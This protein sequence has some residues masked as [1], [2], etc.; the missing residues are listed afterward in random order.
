MTNVVPPALPS[1]TIGPLRIARLTAT[2]AL[3]R[4]DAAHGHTSPLCVAFCNAHTAKLAFDD[5]AYAKVL[6]GMLVLNDGLGID[7]AARA[8][9]HGAFPANLNGTDF[10]PAL[11]RESA[12]PL[13]IFLLGAKRD[14]LVRAAEAIHTRFPQH[15]ITG[16]QDGYFADA[17]LAGIGATIAEGHPDIVLC[18]MGNPRQERVIAA[19][20][21]QNVAP[22]LI[23]VG[24]LFDFL[25][26]AVPRAPAWVRR[27]RMEF[28]YRLL[29]EP[30]RLGRRY[31]VEVVEFLIAVARL[32]FTRPA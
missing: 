27:A 6:G 4:V 20:A 21:E 13:R 25:A 24:A 15:A 22:V 14:V 29:H 12:R 17:E 31:T 28:V 19:L 7:L 23:G 5:P 9:G 18:A 8:L 30:K 1:V 16:M 32:R 2:E 26:D 10:V 3:S 11:L